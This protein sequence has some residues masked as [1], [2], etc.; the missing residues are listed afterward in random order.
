MHI[1]D[2]EFRISGS[3]IPADHGYALYSAV[4]KVIP[5]LH[6][7]EGDR[8]PSTGLW[9]RLGIHP[10]NGRLCGDRKIALGP[11]SRLRVR[12]PAECI[13]DW[14]P[15]SGKTLEVD[16]DAVQVGMPMARALSPVPALRSR[17]VTIKGFLE[18]E[19]FLNAVKKQLT[20]L[21]IQAEAM[22]IPVGKAVSAEGRS[23]SL[24]NKC[25]YIRRT[26]RISNREI[27]GYAL[28]VVNLTAEESLDL[29]EQGVG[30]RRRFGCGIFVPERN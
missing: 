30:G 3:V 14:M 20:A 23:G 22:F 25:P 10:I 26:I 21:N 29:Q 19:D 11:S 7:P 17:L 13:Q 12:L 28:R 24:E 8:D 5:M 15:L 6:P 27:V 1:V 4:S 16:G 18:P 2:L 9:R